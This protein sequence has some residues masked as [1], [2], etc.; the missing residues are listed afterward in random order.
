MEE[1]TSIASIATRNKAD[2]EERA[3]E[4]IQRQYTDGR[5]ILFNIQ[6]QTGGPNRV[7]FD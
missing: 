1:F 4:M 7:K 5:N 6:A 3:S 2:G